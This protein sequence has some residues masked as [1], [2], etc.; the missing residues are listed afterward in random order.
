M[1]CSPDAMQFLISHLGTNRAQTKQ[2]LEKIALYLGDEKQISY[3]TARSVLTDGITVEIGEPAYAITN[4]QPEKLPF[5]F[6]KLYQEGQNPITIIRVALSHL[7]QIY[8]MKQWQKTGLNPS[9]SAKKIIPYL[10][11]KIEGKYT[12][13]IMKFSERKL[14]NSMK[15][16]MQAEKKCKAD[17]QTAKTITQMTFL[18]LSL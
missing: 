9:A 11:P 8:L 15:S 12:N 17:S 2:E 18:G 3:E 14:I 10:F 16:L 7:R 5:L 13:A 4:R 1:Q 6:S